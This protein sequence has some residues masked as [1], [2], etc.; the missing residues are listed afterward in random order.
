MSQYI[1]AY[2]RGGTFFFTL[3]LLNRSQRTL[4]E[5]IDDFRASIEKVRRQRPF[6]IDA[7][8]V[9][10]DH[11]HCIWTLPPEDADF[12]TRWR[13]IKSDFSRRIAAGEQL[14]RRRI[15]KN[16]RGIWQRRFWEHLIRDERDFERHLAYIHYNPVKH[17]HVSR[18]SEWP[19]SSFHRYV[20]RGIYTPDWGATEEIQMWEKE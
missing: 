20:A 2:I 16:E 13:L 12:S 7:M 11:L 4:V 3:A 15:L 9:L 17:G 19:Y 10:P 5:R 8:V 1:R 14:S 18:A 6:Q